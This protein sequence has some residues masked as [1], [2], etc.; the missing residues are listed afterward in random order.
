MQAE[1][2]LPTIKSECAGGFY[3]H[4]GFYTLLTAETQ[5]L[6]V[7]GLIHCT[8]LAWEDKWGLLLRLSPR[9]TVTP[10]PLAQST[11]F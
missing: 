3:A 8:K 9:Q 5:G 4:R 11:Q 2:G 1:R 10:E 7:Q 6:V